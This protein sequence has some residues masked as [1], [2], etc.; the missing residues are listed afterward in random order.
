VADA[1]DSV[2]AVALA[3]W[4]SVAVPENARLS[5]M[6]TAAHMAARLIR[7]RKRRLPIEE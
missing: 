6:T 5:R 3:R 7:L 4:L 2:W 1:A